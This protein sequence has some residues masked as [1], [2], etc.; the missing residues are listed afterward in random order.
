MTAPVHVIALSGGKD[1]T[2]LALRLRELNPTQDYTFLCTPT[3]DELPDMIAHWEKL[4]CL[5]GSP[6]VRLT[7]RTLA[8][9]IEHWDALPNHRQRWCTRE[10]KIQP[11]LAYFASLPAGSALYVGLRADEP[12]RRG[13][14]SKSVDTRFPMRD[15]GWGLPDVNGYLRARGVTIPRRT[16]CA[17]CYAQRL[18]EWWDLW[19]M[20]PEQ[21][22][23]AQ[24][25]EERTEHTFRS[26]SRDTWPASLAGLRAKFE[27]GHVPAGASVQVSLPLFDDQ[28]AGCRVCRL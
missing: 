19:K 28:D 18:G 17:R 3:G 14:Y 1:S 8:D 2:A 24:A 27:A 5:L 20:W 7:N 13:I 16:D 25:D 22:D 10:L 11:C 4:E 21:F 15:W 6:I 12:E 9:W 23:S 26:P